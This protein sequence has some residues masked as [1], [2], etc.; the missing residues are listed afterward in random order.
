MASVAV[1]ALTF[2]GAAA[3]AVTPTPPSAVAQYQEELP[4]STGATS[5]SGSLRRGHATH[6]SPTLVTRVRKQAPADAS[7]LLTM[8]ASPAPDTAPRRTTAPRLGAHTSGPVHA[9]QTRAARPSDRSAVA[10]LRISAASSNS[11]WLDHHTW[12]VLVRLGVVLLLVTGTGMVLA[13]R[14]RGV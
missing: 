4:T 2:V 3:A 9:G 6:L 11:A 5:V 13:R 1:C 8:A 12:S 10:T 7:T 14:R